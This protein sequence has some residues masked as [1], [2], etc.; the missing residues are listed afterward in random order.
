MTVNL[1]F[2][3]GAGAGPES[4]FM[5]TIGQLCEE[6]G[7]RVHWVTFPYWQKVQES[8]TK[9]P[10]DRASVLDAYFV[11]YVKQQRIGVNSPTFLMGKSMGARVAFRTAEALNAAG[12]IGLGFPFHPP[13]RSEKHR[14][15][16]VLDTVQPALILQ[17]ERDPFGNR[18]WVAAHHQALQSRKNLKMIWMHE[19]NHDLVPPKRSGRTSSDAWAQAVAAIHE[20]IENTM[21][22]QQ[23]R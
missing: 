12:V 2:A 6:K 5:Q 15:N 14:L 17:G 9:R 3:H 20:F 7:Y 10:P 19:G 16:E 11:D 23:A 21:A 1:F 4:E 8:G 13:G 18:A 22:S